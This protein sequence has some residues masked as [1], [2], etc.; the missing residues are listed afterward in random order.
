ML[1][2]EDI[3]NNFKR[4]QSLCTKLDEPRATLVANMLDDLSNR[5]ILTPASSKLEYHCA[6]PGGLVEH[7]L[8]VVKQALILHKAIE[9]Y[10]TIP[11]DSVIFAAIMHDMGKVGEPGAAGQDLYLTE[12]SQWHREKLGKMYKHNTDIPYMTNVDYTFRLLMH[13]GINP[14]TDEYLAIK[15]NDGPYDSSNKEFGMRE[16]PLALLIHMADRIACEIEKIQLR[17]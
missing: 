13:Y 1:Q 15:L 14:S 16:P 4:L 10:Q 2:Q 6:Y 12:E 5:L 7:T 8:R 11:V 9:M 17:T 3:I